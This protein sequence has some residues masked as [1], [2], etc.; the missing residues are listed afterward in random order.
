MVIIKILAF[1]VVGLFFTVLLSFAEY[2][3]GRVLCHFE[4][5]KNAGIRM[6]T[7]SGLFP[8]TIPSLC[9]KF[10]CKSGNCRNWTCPLY[11]YSEKVNEK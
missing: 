1:F 2:L 6:I 7:M 3:A 4:L 10:D 9:T 5:S 8:K 11:C